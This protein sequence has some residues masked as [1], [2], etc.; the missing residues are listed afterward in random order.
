MNTKQTL[1]LA[2]IAGTGLAVSLTACGSNKTPTKSVPAVSQSAVKPT[3][4]PKT[5]PKPASPRTLLSVSG[6]GDYE[7]AKFTVGG[8]GDYDVQWTYNEGN[9]GQSVN[10]DVEA[11]NYGDFN[12]TG[13]DQLGTGGSGIVHVYGDAGT[14]YLDVLSEGDW[15][16]KV[17][18][19][20]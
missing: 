6:A 13:P 11:D 15:T 16:L 1:A 17:V 18:T 19:A 5:A 12:F 3:A 2:I 9:F 14:H 7:T 8:N 4:A 20:Q 10:F